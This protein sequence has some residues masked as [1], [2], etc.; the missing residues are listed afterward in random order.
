MEP[1]VERKAES[2]P[3]EAITLSALREEK[4]HAPRTELQKKVRF[5][6]DEQVIPFVNEES[7]DSGTETEEIEN[8]TEEEMVAEGNVKTIADISTSSDS[9]DLDFIP[10][11]MEPEVKRRIRKNEVEQ[12]G[13][14]PI[15]TGSK[16]NELTLRFNRIVKK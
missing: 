8:I 9:E 14:G 16:M 4:N 7:Q 2:L 10:K 6:I 13:L 11:G 3:L 5:L 1:L 15:L 12:K